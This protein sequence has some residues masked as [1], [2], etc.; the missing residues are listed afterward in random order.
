MSSCLIPIVPIQK[1]ENE[2]S[3]TTPYLSPTIKT[4]MDSI[5]KKMSLVGF[6][7]NRIFSSRFLWDF[8]KIDWKETRI[9]GRKKFH[10][11]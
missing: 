2:N 8:F 3:F 10:N 7:K 6:N 1:N 11:Y 4:F 5:I 9:L